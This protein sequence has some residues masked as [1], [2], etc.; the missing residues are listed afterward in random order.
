MSKSYSRIR[1]SIFYDVDGV[2]NNPGYFLAVK[3]MN[4]IQQVIPSSLGKYFDLEGGRYGDIPIFFSDVIILTILI[5]ISLPIYWLI[6]RKFVRWMYKKDY[7]K[8]SPPDT[9]VPFL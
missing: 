6:N 8:V 2:A 4:G 1:D 3:V 7:K 9:E 5:Y